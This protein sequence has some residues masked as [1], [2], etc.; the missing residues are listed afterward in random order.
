[1]WGER[2]RGGE[3]GVC[4]ASSPTTSTLTCCTRLLMP[5]MHAPPP[6]SSRPSSALRRA[7]ASGSSLMHCR[8]QS[9]SPGVCGRPYTGEGWSSASAVD[10]PSAPTVKVLPSGSTYSCGAPSGGSACSS[11]SCCC[12][13]PAWPPPPLLLLGPAAAAAACSWLLCCFW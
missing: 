11:S 2:A 7:D 8:M 12:C 1:V 5:C 4:T 3:A 13:S 6:H 9:T 10:T